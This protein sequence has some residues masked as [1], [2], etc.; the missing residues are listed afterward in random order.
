MKRKLRITGIVLLIIFGFIAGF[1]LSGS[2]EQN[3][4][5]K[6]SAVEEEK[7]PDT[8][9]VGPMHPHI[10]QDEPGN[11]PICG[12]ELVPMKA[13]AVENGNSTEN[14]RQITLTE[15]AKQLARI[16]TSPVVRKDG[17]V[18]VRLV[19][20]IDYDETRQKDVTSWLSGRIDRLRV[21]YTGESIEKGE[22]MA[23]LYSPQIYSAQQELIQALSSARKLD[24]SDV[25]IM[26]ETGWATL[27]AARQKLRLL[28]F[29]QE[30]IELTEKK[31]KPSKQVSVFSTASGVV[32]EK[33]VNEGVYVQPGTKLYTV[34]D[35]STV[36]L[37]LEAYERNLGWLREDQEVTFEVG[38]FPGEVFKGKISFIDPVLNEKTRTTRVR[39]TVPNE[40]YRLKPGMF[41][42]AE[43]RSSIREIRETEKPPLLIPTT[44]ALL[45]GKRAVVYVAVSETGNPVYEGR[46]V[47]LGPRAGDYY[48]VKSG[49]KEGERVVTNGNFKLDSAVQIQAKPSMMSPT[50]SSP[51]GHQHGDIE[52]NAEMESMSDADPEMQESEMKFPGEFTDQLSELYE[53]YFTVTKRLGEDDL[54]EARKEFKSVRRALDQIEMGLL[55]GHAHMVF[56]EQLS[57]A[58][59]A[60]AGGSDAVDLESAREEYRDLSDAVI[61]LERNFGHPGEKKHHLFF[62]PMVSDGA[63]GYWLQQESELKN[64]YFGPDM[65]GCGESRDI[66]TGGEIENE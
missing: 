45:T 24:K 55:S 37:L 33:H 53:T 61:E 10:R 4:V 2:G 19:G 65:L 25:D 63:G 6:I 20:K 17:T 58:K 11:C 50:G 1:W 23:D 57:E 47:V 46:E 42:T 7:D 31:G 44:A 43:V 12:M 13:G 52:E 54:L 3:R 56:M 26:R 59:N 36:W 39:V 62:C 48:V 60:A 16:Q 32:T 21:D 34:A 27:E 49:L 64:P 40:K 35:L 9:W 15:T 41:A 18:K 8:I 28:G 38:A 29:S 14:R 5:K 22:I 66:F 30:Q 51:S